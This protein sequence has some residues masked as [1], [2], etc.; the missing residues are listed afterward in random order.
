M[1]YS[2]SKI[3]SAAFLGLDAVLVEVEVDLFPTEKQQVTVVG[4]PDAAVKE[5]KERVF[6]AIRHTGCKMNT[7]RCTINLAPGELKK[8]GALYDLPIALGVLHALNVFQGLHLNDYLVIGELGLNGEV[9]PVRGVLAAA[10]LARTQGK[11]GILVPQDNAAE[12]AFVSSLNVIPI[13]HLKEALSFFSNPDAVT[14]FQLSSTEQVFHSTKALIDFADIKGQASAKRALEIAA[15]GGHNIMLSGPP[16]TGKT[17]AAK[18]LIGILPELTLEEALEVTKIY[19]IGGLL[20][21]NKGLIKQRPFRSPHHTISYAGMIGG[22]HIPRPGEVSLAHRGILFLDELPEFARTTLEVLRQPLED[23][24]VTVSRAQ[25]HA[26]YPTDF[27]CIAAMNPCPC[28]FLGHPEKPCRDS[29]LQVQKY[30]HKISGPFLDRI[31]LHL[32]VQPVKYAQIHEAGRGESSTDV[33]G[34]VIAARLHQTRRLGNGRTNAHMSAQEV[35]RWVPLSTPCQQILK[36]A[37]DQM[38]LSARS[39]ERLLKVTRTLADLA[40]SEHV[41]EDHLLEALQYRTF[42][43]S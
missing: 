30:R 17:M 11:K 6:A 32:P 25:G 18:A 9:R 14:P 28:G 10:L 21:E 43:F 40:Y 4:L 8:E 37:M 13:S 41:M 12:A 42:V 29:E 23:R 26:T 31:D 36:Q 38:G 5:S 34:R 7:F 20:S 1:N 3:H 16:G 15:A 19:S 22:G 39:H 35:K 2:F 27:L 24:C 33:Q